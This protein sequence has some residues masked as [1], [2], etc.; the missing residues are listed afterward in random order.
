MPSHDSVCG[1]AAPF[2][3]RI[4]QR[5]TGPFFP[6]LGLA[7]V[8]ASTTAAQSGP[9]PCEAAT[10]VAPGAFPAESAWEQATPIN[11]FYHLER[12]DGREVTLRPAE[13]Y[14]IRLL[15]DETRLFVRAILPD[16]DIVA[17]PALADQNPASLFL[18]GDTF[19]LFL[20]PDPASP[21]Y[22]E[23]HVNPV[24]ARYDIRIPAR[25]YQPF[26]NH[27]EWRSGMYSRVVVNGSLNQLDEDTG[28]EVRLAIPLKAVDP[29]RS[30]RSGDWRFSICLYDY[31]YY[32]DDGA[33]GSALRYFSSS[34]HPVLDFHRRGD[35]R[36]LRFLPSE[37]DAQTH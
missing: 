30:L 8:P 25:N 21:T 18:T 35:Y 23:F 24:N 32:Y 5:F 3:R 9:Y 37:Q 12:G 10:G 26:V 19:E 29:D 28:W 13:G 16:R 17:D 27:A 4:L 20:Q 1:T 7:A 31:S 14:D 15:H 22:Y 2:L 11:P 36:T 34:P 33:N 6:L